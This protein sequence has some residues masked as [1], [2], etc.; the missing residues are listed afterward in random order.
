M[1]KEEVVTVGL[2]GCGLLMAVVVALAPWIFGAW[3]VSAVLEALK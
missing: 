1:D 2:V 3:A